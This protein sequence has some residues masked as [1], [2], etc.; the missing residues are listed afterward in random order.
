MPPFGL[1]HYDHPDKAKLATNYQLI[2]ELLD[3]V[4]VTG[5]V[6]LVGN[7]Y[8][9]YLAWSFAAAHPERTSQ[10]VLIDSSGY[11]TKPPF[12][13]KMGQNKI[14]SLAYVASSPCYIVN[15]FYK[16]TYGEG[17]NNIAPEVKQRYCDLSQQRASRVAISQFYQNNNWQDTSFLNPLR[18]AQVKA[19]TLILWV[20]KDGLIPQ[21]H[22]TRFEQDIP[23]NKL[24]IY[25][26]L[27]HVPMEEDPATTLRDV[28]GFL[29]KR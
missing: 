12:I 25:P 14:L 15:H 6:T 18:P 1:S 16:Q 20:Q 2:Q 29:K 3:T 4:N 24:I 10:V 23:N 9:G 11:Q 22:T 13:I 8:G 28:L 19:P 26:A 27:G 17:K 7:S 21:S 5:P